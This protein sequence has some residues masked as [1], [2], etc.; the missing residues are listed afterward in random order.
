MNRK[1]RTWSC[2]NSSAREEI[3]DLI[4]RYNT[5]GDSGRFED[6]VALFAADAVMITGGETYTGTDGVRSVF[7]SA[8]AAL[9]DFAGPS[10]M[11]HST[12]SHQ[13]TLIDQETARSYCYFTVMVGAHGLDHWGRYID[14]FRRRDERWQFT[15]RRILI[16]GRIEGG[17]ATTRQR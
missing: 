7:S 3:R 16:D 10:V 8:G 6:V 9:G 13:I 5:N 14:K 2:G 4:A 17:W 12:A 1:G 15:E 11:R